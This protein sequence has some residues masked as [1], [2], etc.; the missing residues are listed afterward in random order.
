MAEKHLIALDLDGTLLTDEKTISETNKRV[1]KKAREEGHI[2]MIATGRPFR[3]SEMYYHQ[4]GL[5]TPIVNFNGAFMHHPLDEKFGVHHS[6]LDIKVAKDIVEALEDYK[7]HNIIAEV[8]DDVY[9][10]Y[11]DEKLLD[12]FNMGQPN[13]TTG[14]LRRFL[15]ESPTSMLIHSDEDDVKKIRQ[16][17]SAVHAEVIDHRRWAAPWHVVEIVKFGLNKAVGLKR[18]SDYFQ[19]PQDRIIAFGDEDNDLD[20]LEYAG[21]GIAMGNA[22]AEVKN[23]A[24]DQTLTNEEDGIAVYLNDFLNLKAL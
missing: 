18:A 13:V 17:L 8:I 12:I 3:S 5:D 1:I 14:D 19:I 24:N 20:M 4:L 10:H 7:F 15:Q 9:F 23:I 2:V 6:P 16:H 11:H 22:L 21:R